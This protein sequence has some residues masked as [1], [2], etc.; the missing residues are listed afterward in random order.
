MTWWRSGRRTPAWWL[1]LLVAVG[2][3]VAD[4]A[5]QAA[6]GALSGTTVTFEIMVICGAAV[7][8]WIWAWRP[9]TQLGPLAYAWP[10]LY[11]PA[12]LMFAFPNSLLIAT[13]GWASF[14]FGGLVVSQLTLAYPRRRIDS[15]AALWFLL[16]AGYLAQ[17]VQNIG[18]LLWSPFPRSYFYIGPPPWFSLDAWNRGWT[19]EIIVAMPIL[20]AF[21]LNRLRHASRGARRT[22][23]PLILVG[24]V[25]GV[26][27]IVYLLSILFHKQNWNTLESYVL[28]VG[29]IAFA[30]AALL[31]LL[32]TRRA[33]GVV[34][35]L[36]VELGKGGAG[37]VRDALSRAIGDPTLELATLAARSKS[38]GQ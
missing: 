34:G 28:N 23:G 12:D 11:V 21:T 19:I 36:V 20:I 24:A 31:G 35:D 32:A 3:V 30:L 8:L 37:S 27:Y 17:V 25:T 14:N 13:A 5:G 1:A 38:L 29:Q 9:A 10:V 15:R 7:G 26:A 4:V 33:R 22:M 16:L 18:N 2:L 6:S